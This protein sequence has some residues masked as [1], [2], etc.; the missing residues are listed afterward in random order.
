MLFRSNLPIDYFTSVLPRAQY[1]DESAAVVTAGSGTSSFT[2]DNAVEPTE[3][4]LF[5]ISKSEAND[6]LVKENNAHPITVGNNYVF[7]IKSLATNSSLKGF[8]GNLMLLR[9]QSSFLLFARQQRCRNIRRF[10]VATTPILPLRF[11]L[12]LA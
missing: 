11:L 10:R 2:F 12:I 5:N 6:G 9:F 7:G 4:A 8:R 1:G 3:G